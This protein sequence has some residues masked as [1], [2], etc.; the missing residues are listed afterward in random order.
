VIRPRRALAGIVAT[1]ALLTAAAAC[2]S[3]PA[4]SASEY[5]TRVGAVCR[6]LRRRTGALPKPAADANAELLSVGRRALT[7]QRDALRRIQSF[8]PP[9]ASGPM[10]RHWLDL[11]DTALDAGDASL[12]AQASGDLAAARAANARGRAA[13]DRAD[14]VAHTLRFTDCATP[15]A[16]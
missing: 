7:L 5:R 8:E 12:S 16:G 13:S 1:V 6:D 15:T 9:D 14:A 4:P 10:V 2:S 3:D 11:V